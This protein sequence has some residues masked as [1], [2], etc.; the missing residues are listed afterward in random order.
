[1]SLALALALQAASV[2]TSSP[3]YHH[4]DFELAGDGI[5]DVESGIGQRCRR[6]NDPSAITV[7]G[8]RAG[9]AYPLRQMDR[10]YGPEPLMAETHIAGNVRGNIHMQAANLDPASTD[11]SM[12]E[13]IGNRVMVGVQRPF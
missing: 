3:A 11:S 1:M 5:P 13:D 6:G 7:C 4:I 9:G 12:T 8:R 10:V 2:A